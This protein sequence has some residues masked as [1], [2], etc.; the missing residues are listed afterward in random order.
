MKIEITGKGIYGI[1][2]EIEVGTE[3]ALSDEPPAGWAGKYQVIE[4]KPKAD[5]K[6]VTNPK[7]KAD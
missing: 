5:A 1:D 2:G 3:I 6:A 7:T 4:D